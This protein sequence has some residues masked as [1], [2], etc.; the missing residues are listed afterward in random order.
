MKK[1]FFVIFLISSFFLYSQENLNKFNTSWSNVISGKVISKPSIS[2]FGFTFIADSRTI[3]SFSNQ[4][5]LL[6][7]KN[8]SDWRD[9]K[10]LS[11]PQDFY[12]LLNKSNR[13]ISLL[14]QGVIITERAKRQIENIGE[15]FKTHVMKRLVKL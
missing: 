10:L 1:L 15:I 5:T 14:N 3:M 12:L 13:K 11:L 7:E 6:W 9:A 4:G 8:L 2:S